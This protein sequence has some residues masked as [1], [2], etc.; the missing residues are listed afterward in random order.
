M[1]QPVLGCL[2]LSLAYLVTGSAVAPILGH[3]VLHAAILQRRMELPPETVAEPVET[4]LPL[5]A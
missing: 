5:V 1:A 2:V 3:V 4:G